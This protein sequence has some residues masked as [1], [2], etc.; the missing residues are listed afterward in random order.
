[1]MKLAVGWHYGREQ[2][3]RPLNPQPM[4]WYDGCIYVDLSAVKPMI[5][6][7]FHQVMSMRLLHSMK[8]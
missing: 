1:M 6:L 4:A 7:P 5:A 3:Y 8:I 2:D